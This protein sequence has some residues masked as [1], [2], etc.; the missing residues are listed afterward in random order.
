V[1]YSRHLCPHERDDLLPPHQVVLAVPLPA[2]GQG[3]VTP[4]G[5]SGRT[6]SPGLHGVSLEGRGQDSFTAQPG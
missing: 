1:E 2:A 5:R 6:R 4:N 3:A